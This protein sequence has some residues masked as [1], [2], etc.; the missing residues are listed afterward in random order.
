[1]RLAFSLLGQEIIA[2]SWSK[3]DVS[4]EEIADVIAKAIGGPEAKPEAK[5]CTGG[6][7]DRD[8]APLDPNDRYPAW[9]D[10]FGFGL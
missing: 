5:D 2:F 3:D 8:H 4:T 1:M 9:E 10:R 6:S 7:F